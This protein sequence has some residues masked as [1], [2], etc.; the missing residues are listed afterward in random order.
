MK[1]NRLFYGV[2]ILITIGLGLFSR[3]I[4]YPYLSD[5]VNQYLGD[6]IWAG[7][8]FLIF[9]FIFIKKETRLI[10]LYSL[11]FCLFI[12]LSQF[13]HAPWIDSVRA[14]RLGGLVLGFGY[15]WTDLLAYYIGVHLAATIELFLINPFTYTKKLA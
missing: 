14:T 7:M 6:A 5:L 10:A 8:I 2:L 9:R 11:A 1:R 4:A 15:L 13:Y 3:E 12:E